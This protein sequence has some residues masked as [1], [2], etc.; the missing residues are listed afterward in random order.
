VT[1][2]L[3][4]AA[5]T[6]LV[7]LVLL[8]PLLAGRFVKAGQGETEAALVATYKAQLAEIERDLANGVLSAERAE[9]SRREVARRLL[10]LET[11]GETPEE[12]ENPRRWLSLG[13]AAAVPVMGLGLYVWLGTPGLP[14]QPYNQR[15][16]VQAQR[17][18]LERAETLRGELAA[19]PGNAAGWRDLGFIRMM[20]GQS[21]AAATAYRQAIAAGADDPDTFASLAEA[22]IAENEGEVVDPA[23]Q[24]LAESL[25]RNRDQPVALYYVA[26]AMLQDGVTEGAIALWE[27]LYAGLPEGS[28]WRT[29]IAADLVRARETLESGAAP[30]AEP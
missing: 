5:L 12:M 8:Y 22:I 15:A 3:I 10:S 1:F 30:D 29:R 26:H 23:R 16:D 11:P 6:L 9:E 14:S 2:W 18:L 17:A 19:A 24:A 20:L 21:G 27:E 4:V 25:R 28:P 7:L 13:L